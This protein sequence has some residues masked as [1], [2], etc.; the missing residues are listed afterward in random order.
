MNRIIYFLIIFFVLAGTAKASVTIRYK[1]LDNK[2]VKLKV[3][4]DG[5]V[6]EV[7]F[8]AGKKGKVVIK[9]KASTCLFYT[10]CEERM[11]K[12][13]DEIEIVNGCIKK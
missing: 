4:I 9:G 5:E 11:L 12:D 2:E 8:K 6:Q 1:N 7:L 13:E 10:S 3:M